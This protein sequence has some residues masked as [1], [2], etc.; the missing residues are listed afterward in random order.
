MK[1]ILIYV[2][3][4]IAVV[5]AI[6][7]IVGSGNTPS[8]QTEP[9]AIAPSVPADGSAAPEV[10]KGSLGNIPDLAFEDYSGKIVR[11]AD[12]AGT[13]LVLNAWAAWCP[14]CREELPDFAAAQ[15]E[16]GDKVV[17][18]AI[19][20]QESVKTAKSYTDAQGTSDGLVFLMDPKDSFYRAIG[21][22]SM[23]ETLFI[24]AAGET[25]YHKRGPMRLEEIR[26]KINDIL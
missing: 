18:V 21:G 10:A 9:S 17:I 6:V 16:F 5:L 15:K 26:E 23:P 19:N 25:V 13:P 8:G 7:F 22:F 24:N 14:F 1:K 4:G 11:L 2:I 12:F 20:R 3:G